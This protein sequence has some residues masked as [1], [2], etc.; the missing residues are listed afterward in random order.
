MLLWR[1]VSVPV[2]EGEPLLGQ[3]QS[4]IVAEL[5][6]PRERRITVHVLGE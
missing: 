4:L 6:G 1:S 5:D 2:E 3:Y